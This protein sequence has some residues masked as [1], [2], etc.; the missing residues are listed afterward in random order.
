MEEDV[1]MEN[2][3]ESD[4]PDPNADSPTPYPVLSRE[5]GLSSNPPVTPT[6]HGQGFPIRRA[7]S[8]APAYTS[9]AEYFHIGN[10]GRNRLETPGAT[11]DKEDG[12]SES[13]EDASE[14]QNGRRESSVSED[15]DDNNR[16]EM[17]SRHTPWTADF[18]ARYGSP[19]PNG[20][21]LPGFHALPEIDAYWTAPTQP[22][23]YPEPAQSSG[24]ISA[25]A[26]PS[27]PQARGRGRGRGPG[28]PRSGEPTRSKR[29][30]WKKAIK[31]TEH[32]EMFKRPRLPRDPTL[33]KP[34]RKQ[35]RSI[36]KHIDP[37]TPYRESAAAANQAYLTGDLDQALEHIFQAISA[38]PEVF[39]GHLLVAQILEQQGRTRDAVYAM[40]N[41]AAVKR[42]AETW[43]EVAERYLAFEGKDQ[44]PNDVVSALSCYSQA[45]KLDSGN[46]DMREA[47]LR[48]HLELEDW[49]YARMECKALVRLRPAELDYVRQYASLCNMNGKSDERQRALLAYEAAF[50][51]QTNQ[52]SPDNPDE[53]WDHLNVYLD[54]LHRSGRP[55]DGVAQLKTL[56][57]WLLGRKD[58]TF[59]DAWDWDDREFDNDDVRRAQVSQFQQ[60]RVTRDPSK[61]GDGLPLD[62][63]VKMGMFRAQMGLMQ[64][65]EALRHLKPLRRLS[66]DV[67]SFSDMFR[68]VAECLRKASYPETAITFYEP[69]KRHPELV[70]EDFWMGLAQC[71]ETVGRRKDAEECYLKTIE[72]SED[73][74]NAHMGLVKLYHAMDEKVK[75]HSIANEII[76]LGHTKALHKEKLTGSGQPK[77][78]PD[79]S[80]AIRSHPSKKLRALAPR[81]S[82]V[83]DTGHLAGSD[84]E[85]R[86]DA[87][88]PDI[89]TGDRAHTNGTRPVNSTKRLQQ[90]REQIQ[91]NYLEVKALWL[92][93]ASS[94]N[95]GAIQQWMHHANEMTEVFRNT[96][97]FFPNQSRDKYFKGLK[98]GTKMQGSK[99]MKDML[100]L[101][102]SLQN[103]VSNESDAAAM[104]AIEDGAPHDFHDIS[105]PEWHRI[106]STLALV[107]AQRA[108]Q[109]KCYDILQNILMKANIL[110]HDLALKNATLAVCICCAMMFND[111]RFMT[112]T[113]HQYDFPGVDRSA[114]EARLLAASGQLSHGEAY[115]YHRNTQH[116]AQFAVKKQDFLDMSPEMRSE[117]D[118]GNDESRLNDLAKRNRDTGNELDPGLLTMYAHI[119]G[120]KY[121]NSHV[122]LSYLFRALALQPENI[123]V[124]LSI[125]ITYLALSTQNDVTNRQYSIA[126]GQA[127]LHRYYDLRTASGKVSHLQEAEYNIGRA[128]HLLGRAHLAV[129]AYEK[130][131]KLSQQV[132]QEAEVE[133]KASGGAEDFAQEAALALRN[134]YIGA[135][136]EDAARAVSE[137]WLVL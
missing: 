90:Q 46:C 1:E 22:S 37:G 60:G 124:N 105:F 133:G 66:D 75:A 130:T 80:V 28:R 29:R 87:D 82:N 71:Y 50:K 76:R 12:E 99:R 113:V 79:R 89:E 136:N 102:H 118:W 88:E 134:L 101:K 58:D 4:Y 123:V 45:V 63:R 3:Y 69:I 6:G 17:S 61:Y 78:R 93:L 122:A 25:Y 92:S 103:S 84:D 14:A 30:N 56:A 19:Q 42:S 20:A 40:T 96:N 18:F 24:Y 16:Y 111:S 119:M 15:D 5:A 108:D 114:K 11:D 137:E 9:L 85:W 120:S 57:R 116:L 43:V 98:N 44:D 49:R 135:G 77:P 13:E 112:E 132:Q 38:N 106:L 86:F 67:E 117:V 74:I 115:L 34:G 110:L 10:I 68:D 125:A 47:K 73:H 70:D 64:Q 109:E 128:W 2:D 41:G 131:L 8:A 107:Y 65:P 26:D 62:I 35:G 36:Q 52:P 53:Y 127:F 91:D 55:H 23:R 83:D 48:L 21:P 126:Q 33:R 81:R 59:W 94:G 31:G 51:L 129:P 32:A 95:E 7:G 121:G 54:L 97:E 39:H 27:T 72:L 100:A 104:R